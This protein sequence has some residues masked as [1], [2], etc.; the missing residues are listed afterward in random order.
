NDQQDAAAQQQKIR[1]AVPVVVNRVQL[2]RRRIEQDRQVARSDSSAPERGERQPFSAPRKIRK[3]E[4]PH[5]ESRECKC[6]PRKQRKEPWLRLL[7]YMHAVDVGLDGPG[8]K[9]WPM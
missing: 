7:K 3:Q 5:R 4:N 2:D 9:L 8:Q 1:I 6:R